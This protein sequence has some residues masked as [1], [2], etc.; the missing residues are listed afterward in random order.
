MLSQKGFWSYV[1][2]DDEAEGERISRLARDVANQFEMLTGEPLEVFLDRD[3]IRWGEDWRDRI[4]SSLTSVAFFIPVMTPRYFMSSECRREFQ[5]FARRAVQ[6]GIKDLILPLLYV[7]VPG[8]QAEFPSD[9]IM[10]LVRSFQWEDWRELRFADLT[11]E[12]YRRGVARLAA[13]LVEV[14]RRMEKADMMVAVEQPKQGE[15]KIDE[16]AP[17]FLDHM[18]ALEEA[19]PKLAEVMNAINGDIEAVGQIMQKATAELHHSNRSGK[20]LAASRLLSARKVARR[21]TEPAE[22]I[23]V[24]A[25]ALVSHLHEANLGI[26][27]IIEHAAD[28]VDRNPEAKNEVCEFFNVIRVLSENANIGLGSAQGMIDAIRPIEGM[29]RDLRPILR[30][31]R[32][33]LTI[34]VEATEVSDEWIKLIEVSPVRCE[35]LNVGSGGN[36]LS[37]PSTAELSAQSAG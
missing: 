29:S 3:A 1:H 2:A 23:W 32:Q 19:L 22:R 5:F 34:L 18:A 26:C 11:S 35:D 13:H 25:N 9:E 20:N 14:N 6:L 16:E 30:R 21:I 37:N 4:D 33:G 36:R 7:D 24:S 12:G 8:I 17:G 27:A 31:L 10:L 15:S 28:E